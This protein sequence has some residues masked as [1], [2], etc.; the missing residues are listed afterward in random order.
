[1]SALLARRAC[2]GA[3]LRTAPTSR[4]ALLHTANRVRLCCT[5]PI[6]SGF[7]ALSAA[8]P[9][10]A[11]MHRPALPL[12]ASTHRRPYCCLLEGPHRIAA[13]HSTHYDSYRCMASPTQPNCTRQ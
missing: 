8:S 3:G 12:G 2:A 7:F 6:A 9:T 5:P 13:G 11:A 10:P 1:M 4:P